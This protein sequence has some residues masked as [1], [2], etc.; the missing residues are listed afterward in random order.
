MGQ[1]AKFR[2][3]TPVTRKNE[4]PNFILTIMMHC[5]IRAV[6]RKSPLFWLKMQALDA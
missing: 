1:R 3:E 2:E 5:T 4:E 6:Q